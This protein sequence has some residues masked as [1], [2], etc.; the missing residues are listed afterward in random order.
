MEKLLRK[1]GVTA[2]SWPMKTPGDPAQKGA[3]ETYWRNFKGYRAKARAC[4]IKN[5]FIDDPD[6]PKK[7]SEAIDFKGTCEEMCPEFEKITR[8]MENDVKGPEKEVLPGQAIPWPAPHKMIKQLARSAAGQDAPLPEDVRSPA[9]LRRTLDYLMDTILSEGNLPEVHGFLWDRTRAIRRD[10]TFQAQSMNTREELLDQVYCLEQITRFH[11]IAL[12]QMSPRRLGE[13]IA[14]D[15]S[16][17]QEVE[18]LGKALLSLTHAYEDCK[19]YKVKCEN[20]AEFRSY[21]IVFN[22]HYPGIM[23]TVQDW[24]WEFWGE[25]DEIRTAISIIETLQ[26]VWDHHGPLKPESP[27]IIAQNAYTKFFSIVQDSSIS[28]TMACFAEIHFNSV[29]KAA[30]KTILSSYKK[31][32]D[33]TKEWTLA[34]LNEILRF[35]E[36][37]EVE[38]FC[39][40]YS[41]SILNSRDDELYLSLSE[42]YAMDDP[43]PK[44][45]Q[46][47]SSI[48]EAKRGDRSL[49]DA[50][51]QTIF[52]EVEDD[53]DSMFVKESR[54]P[55]KSNHAQVPKS[56]A[57]A[58]KSAF[59]WPANDVGKENLPPAPASTFGSPFGFPSAKATVETPPISQNT[60]RAP[61]TSN[62][63][64]FAGTSAQPTQPEKAL[65][66]NPITSEAPAA[67]G[68]SFDFFAKPPVSTAPSPFVPN[69]SIQKQPEPPALDGEVQKSSA[70]FH[71]S[72]PASMPTFTP[73]LAPQPATNAAKLPDFASLAAMKSTSSPTPAPPPAPAS[74][75]S[76][77]TS[78]SGPT[79][80]S[81]TGLA[82]EKESPAMKMPTPQLPVQ[83]FQPPKPS[84]ESRIPA[85]AEW[86]ATGVNGIIPNFVDW[87]IERILLETVAQYQSE[88]EER[89]IRKEEEE[90]QKEADAFRMRSLAVR[91]CHRWRENAHA[92]WRR[93]QAL[94][95]RKIRAE[96]MEE[97]KAA[98]EA[99]KAVDIVAEFTAATKRKSQD[100]LNP[101]R[102]KRRS[103][104]DMLRATGILDFVHDPNREIRNVVRADQAPRRTERSES[105][106]VIPPPS[107]SDRQ[108]AK[109]N[110]KHS[111]STGHLRTSLLSD[112]GYLHGGSRSFLL[113]ANS[114]ALHESTKGSNVKTDYFRMKARGIMTLPSG[115]PISN[116]AAKHLLKHKR[117]VDSMATPNS[118]TMQLLKHKRSFDGIT[119]TSTPRRSTIRPQI[120]SVPS[121][122][123]GNKI[124]ESDDELSRLKERARNMVNGGTL[125]NTPN[126]KRAFDDDD[127]EIFAKAKRIREAMD[128][129]AEWFRE[130][131][132]RESMTRSGS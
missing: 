130:E 74:A 51:H 125:Q 52:E 20:E 49:Y 71:M 132:R 108:L 61:D 26:N 124:D 96:Q 105:P 37:E 100:D 30:L 75:I 33:Q 11:V 113:P 80:L 83:A 60:G 44:L 36:E 4:L 69:V 122:R 59:N 77:G 28:Y 115:T 46:L 121:Q 16:E 5:K 73:A 101:G 18:Q 42:D 118:A 68:L 65:Q 131:I 91:Y 14:D 85:F 90:A 50:I 119:K 123:S 95:N 129:G 55:T 112:P 35:D 47:H 29:R 66:P 53:S 7:L 92:I 89:R 58:E 116:S 1:D 39:E 127:E 64:N 6:K 19:G 45:S 31:Q 103:S 79:D 87:E 110:H 128:E 111:R 3:V 82:K 21:Y 109:Q 67:K 13:K 106:L 78:S 22:A 38:K 76:F 81:F 15:F 24:G 117:S 72:N 120:R 8:I 114:P 32:R 34:A 54:G 93:R 9:A 62:M 63:F 56:P 94:E 107:F 41:L 88:E 43:F 98:R 97:Y 102:S 12:H 84:L 57:M 126:N 25:S 23:E 40:A 27:A 86:F 104:E 48:V 70:A 10:F 2:P 17:Q 99:A